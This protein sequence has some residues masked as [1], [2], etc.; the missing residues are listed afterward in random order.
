[1]SCNR[2]ALRRFDGHGTK[3]KPPNSAA[4]TE[5]QAALRRRLAERDLQDAGL[6][7]APTTH[8]KPVPVQQQAKPIQQAQ[9]EEPCY[10]LSS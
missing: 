8:I 10:S 6:F 2:C 1:M 9:T 3:E 7:T 4:A 5:A